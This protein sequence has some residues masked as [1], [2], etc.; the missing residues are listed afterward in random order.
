MSKYIEIIILTIIAI[1]LGII[2]YKTHCIE[3]EL[4]RL[5]LYEVQEDSY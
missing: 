2:I 3:H 4:S 5:Q 1:A